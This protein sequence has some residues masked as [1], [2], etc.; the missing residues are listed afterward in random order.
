MTNSLPSTLGLRHVALYVENLQACEDFYVNILGMSVEW[1][2]DEDN[3]YL[4]SSG[5]DNL[6]LHRRTGKLEEQ[7]QRLDHLGFILKTLDDVDHWYALAVQHNVPIKQ[8]P[9]TH[10][11][12][13]RS[14]Y[15]ADPDGTVVQLIYHPPIAAKESLKRK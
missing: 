14:F 9:K 7:E 5:Q 2:P 6:A 11:D 8:P 3:V 10:R 1:R 15:C 4:T 13:A 12:G